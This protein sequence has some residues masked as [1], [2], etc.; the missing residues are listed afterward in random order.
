MGGG[1]LAGML[2][3]APGAG[4][5]P[6]ARWLQTHTWLLYLLLS[7]IKLGLLLYIKMLI[8]ARSQSQAGY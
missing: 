7:S 3:L 1:E 6:A 8:T 2:V 5:V 4:W